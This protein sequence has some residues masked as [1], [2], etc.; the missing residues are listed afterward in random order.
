MSWYTAIHS[1]IS[2]QVNHKSSAE[3]FRENNSHLVHGEL[4]L[5]TTD[6]CKGHAAEHA[7]LETAVK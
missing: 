3:N 6:T 7:E 2:L 5:V 1:T 4:L